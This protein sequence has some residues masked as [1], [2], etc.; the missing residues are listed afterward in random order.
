MSQFIDIPPF[1]SGAVP[2]GV[3]QAGWQIFATEKKPLEGMVIFNHIIQWIGV[4]GLAQWQFLP[5]EP[6]AAAGADC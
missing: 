2:S 6:L 1:E 3:Q 4:N 5:P